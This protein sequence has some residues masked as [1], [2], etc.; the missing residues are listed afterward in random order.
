MIEL[1]ER[2]AKDFVEHKGDF[3]AVV[4]YSHKCPVCEHFMPLLEEVSQ[5]LK[6]WQFV[7]VA[8]ESVK[9]SNLFFQPNNFPSLYAFKKGERVFI[10]AG[11]APKE[12]VIETLNSIVDGSFKSEAEIE[13]EQMDALDEQE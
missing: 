9:S 2:C 10:A 5:E 13:Q 11:A 1:S 3:I 6:D 7:K 4:W 12:A 8:Y